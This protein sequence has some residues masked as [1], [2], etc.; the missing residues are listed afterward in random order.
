MRISRR[1]FLA[2]LGAA[3]A[4]VGADAFG[5]E[6][7]RVLLTRHD[8]R[9]P[10]LPSALNGIRIAQITDVHFPGNRMA[11]RAA[12][13]H[14]QRE[15]PEIVVLNGDMTETRDAVGQVREFATSAR[16]SLATVAILGN[17]EYRA[18]VTG[19]EARKIYRNTGVE[20][21]INQSRVITVGSS[22]IALVG[23]DDVLLGKPNLEAARRDVPPG[24]LEVWLFHEPEFAD[25]LPGGIAPLP[26]LLLAGHTHGG[27]IRIPFVPPLKP[28]GAG[29]FLEGWYRDTLAPLYVSHGVGTTEIQARFRCPAELPIFTLHAA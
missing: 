12:L 1:R 3:G 25:M 19:E 6:A 26:I 23:L 15:R 10:Q 20:L 9:V 27:Q 16:G 2:G 7:N 14:V 11:A 24:T 13:A 28:V 22:A 8:V 21:L 4:A 5:L 29:R 17:W 18:G